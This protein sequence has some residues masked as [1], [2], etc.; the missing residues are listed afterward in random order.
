MPRYQHTTAEDDGESHYNVTHC[1]D[2]YVEVLSHTPDEKTTTG[3]NS[4]LKIEGYIY[5]TNQRNE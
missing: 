5:E 2:I 4:I 1:T 3:E